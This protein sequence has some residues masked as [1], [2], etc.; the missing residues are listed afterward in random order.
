[1]ILYEPILLLI[2]GVGLF[3]GKILSIDRFDQKQ[4]SKNSQTTNVFFGTKYDKF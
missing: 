2:I 3:A 4:F 1:M